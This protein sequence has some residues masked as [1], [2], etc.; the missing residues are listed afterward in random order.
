MSDLGQV[1]TLL[2]ADRLRAAMLELDRAT[3]SSGLDELGREA[4]ALARRAGRLHDDLVGGRAAREHFDAETA[5]LRDAMTEL[6]G[7]VETAERELPSAVDATSTPGPALRLTGARKV[8]PGG[9]TI[10]PVDVTLDRGRCSRWWDRTE[11]ARR[12]SCA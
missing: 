3:F 8:Y 9:A 10:G 1:R 4:A 12:P 5:R 2:A 7:R 11:A 6:V